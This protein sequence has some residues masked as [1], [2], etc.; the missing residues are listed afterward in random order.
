MIGSW[1]NWKSLMVITAVLIVSGTIVYSQY[2][3]GKIAKEERKNVAAWVEAQRTILFS[4]DTVSINLATKIITEND[5]IPIIETTEKEIITGNFL[6]LDSNEVKS[7]PNYLT[8]KLKQFK[9]FNRTPVVS[10]LSENPYLANKYY[11]GESRL[12]KETKLY[13]IIQLFVVALFI[14][15][16]I[17][18]L[19]TNYKSSQNQLWASLAKETAHQLGTPVSSLEGWLEI[20]KENQGNEK[21]VP[22]IAKDVKRL[23][24]ITDRFGKIGSQPKLEKAN[25]SEQI[26]HIL[27]YMKKRAGGSVNF[28]SDTKE[29]EDIS[30]MISPPF[31][32]G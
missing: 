12:L 32:I 27:N 4:S 8:D 11:Y 2:L 20:L 10:I 15:V 31:L 5:Q 22:E 1:M 30:V 14:I 23:Q 25:L 16:A 24:L 3:A 13:P 19:Q 17:L 28:E 18:M 9:R 21:I 7:N 6:N 26:N 29:L